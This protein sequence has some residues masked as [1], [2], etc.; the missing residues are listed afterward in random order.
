MNYKDYEIKIKNILI[1]DK[2][3]NNLENN[4]ID[5]II[6][7]DNFIIFLNNIKKKFNYIKLYNFS[8]KEYFYKYENDLLLFNILELICKK[9]IKEELFNNYIYDYYEL[10][11]YIID[12][13]IQLL[14][15]IL[16][17][18]YDICVNYYNLSRKYKTDFCNYKINIK[19]KINIFKREKER[20]IYE[21]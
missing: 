16:T 11:Y 19:K 13:R 6:N 20:F 17:E 2:L 1:N 14:N 10:T 5:D 15:V 3:S 8:S 4:N 12:N 18:Y 21:R 7:N 9:K